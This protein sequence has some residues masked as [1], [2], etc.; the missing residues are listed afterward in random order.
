MS[1]SISMAVMLNMGKLPFVVILGMS[2]QSSGHKTNRGSDPDRDCEPENEPCERDANHGA[3]NTTMP[4]TALRIPM[5][6]DQAT[7][8]IASR[9]PCV[10]TAP[11]SLAQP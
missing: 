8:S 11:L 9:L 3:P 2:E 4:V 1:S 7:S 6:S 5:I 10:M